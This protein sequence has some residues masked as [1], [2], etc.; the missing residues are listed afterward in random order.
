MTTTRDELMKTLVEWGARLL[1][2]IEKGVK[3]NARMIKL[4]VGAGDGGVVS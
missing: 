2:R 4:V 1:V 3:V